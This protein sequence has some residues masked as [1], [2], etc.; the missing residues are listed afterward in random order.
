MAETERLLLIA[1]PLMDRTPA[2]ERAA[3][4]ARVKSAALHIVAFDY[5]EGIANVGFAGDPAIAAL[6]DGYVHSHRHWLEEQAKGIRHMGVDTTTEVVWVERP[7]E[8][9]VAHIREMAPAMVIKDLQHASWLTRALSTTLDM[10]LLF[11]CTAPLH[12]VANVQHGIP[13]KIVAAVDPF[14]V[15]D[16]Y[17][18]L[19]DRII[20]AAEQL[21]AQCGAQLDLLY[22][23]DMSYIYALD[24]GFS[25]ASSVM[26]E[27]YDDEAREFQALADRF[28]VPPERRHMVT[29]NPARVIETFMQDNAVDVVVLGTVHREVRSKLLGSTTEQLVN[30]LPGSLLAVNPRRVI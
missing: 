15:E 13:R 4:L 3:A 8:E 11:D 27:L 21:A 30:H 25:N 2:L 23:Y 28:G 20:T 26:G 7:Y 17:E 16:Q 6:R 29:G 9:I 14:R 18:G 19:N 22:A 1:P 5:I 24:G 10:Q 12:L